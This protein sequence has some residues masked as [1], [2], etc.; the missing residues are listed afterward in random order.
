MAAVD[1]ELKITY[2]TFVVG[3]TVAPGSERLIDNYIRITKSFTSASVEFD[4]VISATTEALFQAAIEE[5]EDAFREPFKDLTVAQGA[6]T[7][8]DLSPSIDSGLNTQPEIIKT[9]DERDTGRSRK[10]T[11]RISCDMPADNAPTVGIQESSTNVA[12]SPARKRQVTIS[13]VGTAISGT[14]SRAKYESIIEGFCSTIIASLGSGTFELGEEPLTDNDYEN[15]LITFTRV[16]DEIIYPEAGATDDPAIVRQTFHISRNKVAPGDDANSAA[17]RLVELSANF[18][19]WIDKDVTQDLNSKWSSVKTWIYAEIGK[20]M[21]GP[22]AITSTQPTFDFGENKISGRVAGFVKTGGSVISATFKTDLFQRFGV[23]LVPAWSG[24]SMSKYAYQGPGMITETTTYTRRVFGGSSQNIVGGGSGGGGAGIIPS[25]SV[26]SNPLANQMGS[27][28]G[29]N[30]PGGGSASSVG[31]G[32]PLANQMGG[33]IQFQFPG[34]GGG[35][36]GGAGASAGDGL[37]EGA[38]SVGDLVPATVSIMESDSPVKIGR[39]GFEFTVTDLVTVKV[40]EYYKPI[41]GS[42]GT[43]GDSG[44]TDVA[45][46]GNATP[47]P[48]ANNPNSP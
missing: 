28:I 23:V 14:D 39:D 31:A 17:E 5:C 8:L 4:F 15:K 12:Y 46:G 22:L 43:G 38:I 6:E 2:G 36:G 44:N 48:G 29:W 32:N 21:P 45:T 26:G 19:C 9:D 33:T 13:G 25:V 16:F 1:R 47:G 24:D 42:S 34:G 41:Q 20:V 7:I 30:F 11:V 3:G 37:E 18:E 40:T 27:I 10:Y 35:G